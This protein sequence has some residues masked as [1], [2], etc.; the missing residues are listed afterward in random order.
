[1]AASRESRFRELQKET[2]ELQDDVIEYRSTNETIREVI[3]DV[4]EEI[5]NLSQ[6]YEALAS[7]LG[8]QI[9]Q[10]EDSSSED[11][12]RDEE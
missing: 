11:D 8:V 6:E 4:D 12:E 9:E 3:S 5:A 1:M 2:E 10:D 7:L